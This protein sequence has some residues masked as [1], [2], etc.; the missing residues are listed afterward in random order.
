MK[1]H[2]WIISVCMLFLLSGCTGHQAPDSIQKSVPVYEL[3]REQYREFLDSPSLHYLESNIEKYEYS[4]DTLN[5]K[6]IV[7]TKSED[8]ESTESSDEGV[9]RISSTPVYASLIEAWGSKPQVQQYLQNHNIEEDVDGIVF[10]SS[11][12]LPCSIGVR[13]ESNWY[14]V[15]IDEYDED[16][17]QNIHGDSYIY[18]LYTH[19]EIL[20]KYEVVDADLFINGEKTLSVKMH[21]DYAE[22]PALS[23]FEQLGAS[24]QRQDDVITVMYNGN[25]ATITPSTQTIEFET[26]AEYGEDPP[27]GV[28]CFFVQGAEIYLDTATAANVLREF[29]IDMSWS[30]EEFAVHI[31]TGETGDGSLS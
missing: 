8:A 3:T 1:T 18:R 29:G 5:D 23:L 20:K 24:V 30:R 21:Y 31:N 2:I 11:S 6:K 7:R 22:I 9:F 28:S 16:Y 4:I 26:G 15:T 14:F 25:Y 17:Q 12:G 27:G 13:T 10:L 19:S